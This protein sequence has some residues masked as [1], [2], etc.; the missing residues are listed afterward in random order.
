MNLMM[1][2]EMAAGGFGDRVAIGSRDGGLTFQQLFDRAGAA[3]GRFR[4]VGPTEL[5]DHG[6]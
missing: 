5:M 6:P 1:L 4:E 3:A 2:L